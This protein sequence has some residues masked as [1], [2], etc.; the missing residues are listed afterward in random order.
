MICE[1][2]ICCYTRR[3]CTKTRTP[4]LDGLVELSYVHWEH[5]MDILYFS[6]IRTLI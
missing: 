3:L 1:Y 2:H 5:V 4:V 6:L